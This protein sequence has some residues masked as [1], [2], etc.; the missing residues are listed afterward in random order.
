MTILPVSRVLSLVSPVPG[1]HFPH[2][3]GDPNIKVEVPCE[4]CMERG[5]SQ[6]EGFVVSAEEQEGALGAEEP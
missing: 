4:D 6:M 2:F 1:L 5:Q 3:V